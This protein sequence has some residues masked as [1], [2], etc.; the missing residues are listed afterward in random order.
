MQ[1]WTQWEVARAVTKLFRFPMRYV[2]G[3][4]SRGGMEFTGVLRLPMRY[5]SGFSSLGGMEFTGVLRPIA[6]PAEMAVAEF[7]RRAPEALSRFKREPIR[8]EDQE[9]LIE[10]C[11]ADEAR[12]V[13]GPLMTE[14]EMDGLWG[15]G[16]WAPMPRFL[17]IQ[18][19][20]KKRPIDDGARYAH[21]MAV[22][23]DETIE[24]CTAAQPAVHAQALVRAARAKQCLELL[25]QQRLEVEA[26]M[27]LTPTDGCQRIQQK[28]ML[29]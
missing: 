10:E 15:R 19:N 9:F 29:M 8:P 13:A 17:H 23:F 6:K 26:K 16:R 12:G 3:F 25:K 18:P 28:H 1:K 27:F 22:G 2:S 20:G 5:V 11:R 14:A 7:R 24:C 4:A 21:N